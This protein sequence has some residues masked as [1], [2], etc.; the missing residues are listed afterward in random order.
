MNLLEPIGDYLD[1]K[2]VLKGFIESLVILLPTNIFT[3]KQLSKADYKSISLRCYLLPGSQELRDAFNFRCVIVDDDAPRHNE[4]DPKS[5]F[6][7]R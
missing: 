7:L 1:G 5:D 4:E 3:K 2:R 6:C